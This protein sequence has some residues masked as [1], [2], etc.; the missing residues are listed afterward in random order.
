MTK[1]IAVRAAGS[2]VTDNVL[3]PGFFV[4]QSKAQRSDG[5][6]AGALTAQRLREAIPVGRT[7]SDDDLRGIIVYLCGDASAYMTG[8]SVTVDGGFTVW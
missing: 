2:G 4:S 3:C 6:T 1:P 8:Q 7:G 5:V